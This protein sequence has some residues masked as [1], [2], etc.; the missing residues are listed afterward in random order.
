M[1]NNKKRKGF[2]LLSGQNLSI[3]GGIVGQQMYSLYIDYTGTSNI[4]QHGICWSK[5]NQ[6]PTYECKQGLLV[7]MTILCGVKVYGLMENLMM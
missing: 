6:N 4:T 3:R 2:A 5:T 1:Y 7:Y